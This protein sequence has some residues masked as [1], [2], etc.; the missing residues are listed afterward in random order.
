MCYEWGVS[1][2]HTAGEGQGSMLLYTVTYFATRGMS[3]K[4]TQLVMGRSH[5]S[6]PRD[7][8]CFQ[9]GVF[10]HQILQG[11]EV[12]F[13]LQLCAGALIVTWCSQGLGG[14]KVGGQWNSHQE[15]STMGVRHWS[16]I[17]LR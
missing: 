15:V 5:P 4:L 17:V 16:R 12:V 6:L 7:L 3:S 10:L 13:P 11:S 8:V 9:W 1:P 14:I 2:G